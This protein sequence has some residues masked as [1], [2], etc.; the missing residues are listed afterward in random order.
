MEIHAGDIIAYRPDES[1][2]FAK[3]M[4]FAKVLLVYPDKYFVEKM[5]DGKKIQKYVS[6]AQVIQVAVPTRMRE[7]VEAVWAR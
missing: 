6:P 1:D 4:W 7:V 3:R 2:G 5:N